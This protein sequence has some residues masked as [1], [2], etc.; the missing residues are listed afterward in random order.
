MT[1]SSQ[2]PGEPEGGTTPA[3]VSGARDTDIAPMCPL[4]GRPGEPAWAFEVAEQLSLFEE[5]GER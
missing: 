4:P 2:P 5:E 3:H 1:G